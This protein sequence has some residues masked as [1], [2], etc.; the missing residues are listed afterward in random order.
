MAPP[1]IRLQRVYDPPP[2]GTGPRFLV[3]R[4][5]PRGVRRESLGLTAWARD[6]A[7]SASLRKWYG[8]DPALWEEFQARYRAE[9]DARPETWA[10]LLE[11]ARREGGATLLFAA[12]DTA[13]NSAVVLKAYLEARL[14]EGPGG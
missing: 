9:L 5:W 12:R 6:V 8:H 7:P 13:R 1:V 3:D 10:P 2:P 14:A 11:G 4:L